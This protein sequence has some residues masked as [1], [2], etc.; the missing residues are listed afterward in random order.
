MVED[1]GGANAT[2]VTLGVPVGVTTTEALAGFAFTPRVMFGDRFQQ[3]IV[4]LRL[5]G[6]LYA[7]GGVLSLELGYERWFGEAGSAHLVGVLGMDAGRA[8]Y[9]LLDGGDLNEIQ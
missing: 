2:F 7:L 5:G 8:I 6:T 1:D 3:S 4:A 9:L